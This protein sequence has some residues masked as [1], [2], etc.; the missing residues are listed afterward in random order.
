M[1]S[2]GAGLKKTPPDPEARRTCVA[3]LLGRKRFLAASEARACL[4]STGEATDR[5][6]HEPASQAA[7]P[8]WVGG[9]ALRLA[10]SV[11]VAQR[12][13]TRLHGISEVPVPPGQRMEGISLC[14]WSALAQGTRGSGLLGPTS[15]NTNGVPSAVSS[16]TERPGTCLASYS[17]QCHDQ[18]LSSHCR[19]D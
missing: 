15:G 6:D 4:G 1:S 9:A 13:S 7:E 2:S 5:A 3:G 17:L 8:L 12:Q 11:S 14:G 19:S 18:S 10:R 16:G